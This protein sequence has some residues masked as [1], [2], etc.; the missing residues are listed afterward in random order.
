[1]KEANSRIS[2]LEKN[3]TDLKKLAELKSQAAAQAQKTATPPAAASAMT[4]AKPAEVPATASAKPAEVPAAT[5]AATDNG[6]AATAATPAPAAAPGVPALSATA[7][8]PAAEMP[9]PKP[10]KKV[11]P[12]PPPP[13]PSFIEQNALLV[14]G[15]G[16][17]LI[18]AIAGFLGFRFWKRRRDSAKGQGITVSDIAASSVFGAANSQS[19]NTA[20]PGQT[21]FGHSTLE[22]VDTGKEGVDPIQE[23]EVYMAYGRD[24]QAEEILIDAMQKDP[25]NQA[26]LL[27]LLEIYSGRK[28]LPQFN[29]V[30][31][32]LHQ[33]SGGSGPDW[34]KAAVLGRAL[35]PANP[36]YGGG[37][38]AAPAPKPVA[39]SADATMVM[40]APPEMAAPAAA[41]EA[42]TTMDFDVGGGGD[43]GSELSSA[44]PSAEVVPDMD[45][46]LDLGGGAEAP[47]EGGNSI[48]FDIASGSSASVESAPASTAGD[49][50]LDFNFDLGDAGGG[51]EQAAAP[52]DLSSINLDLDAPAAGSG[53]SA[54]VATKLELANAYKEMGDREGAR[55][56]LQEVLSEGSPA[57]QEAARATLAELG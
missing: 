24:G 32:D 47:K 2:D 25:G 51:G 4:A 7:A 22:G 44:A 11:I 43:A 29:T 45:F 41:E 39:A 17:G 3:L 55:E 14:Y 48:D 6:A 42:P 19:V 46:D 52:M 49:S 28:S 9:K 8:A 54:E 10:K 21:D 57:Q 30:A 56:L 35:D 20:T 38:P 27:K 12:A 13:E 18:A 53:D 23:A 15:G 40:A 33:R 34:A 5:I 37:A 36:L 1:L 31:A 26:V 16:G 50:G